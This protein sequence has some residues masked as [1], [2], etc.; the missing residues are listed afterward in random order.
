MKRTSNNL[1]ERPYPNFH[2]CRLEDPNKYPEKTY[3]K[4]DQKHNG[5]CIDVVYGIRKDGKSE[6]QALRFD[7][8][9]WTE[10]DART[11]CKDRGGT[12]EASKKEE[13]KQQSSEKT[14]YQC[15]CIECGYK[16]TSTTH[17]N[18]L[19]CPKCGGRMRRVE[20]PGPGQKAAPVSSGSAPVE[21][22]IQRS[23]LT[24]RTYQVRFDTL[25]EKTRSIEAVIATENPVLVIDWNRWEIIEEVL[26]MS[27]FRAPANGQVPLL[28]THDRSTIQKQLGSTR[29]LHTEGDKLIGRN[30]FSS[31]PEAEH[32]WTLTKEGHLTDNSAGYRVINSVIIP[33]G[34]QATVEGRPFK[35]SATRDLRISTEWMHGETSVCPIGADEDAKN[36]NKQNVSTERN[37]IMDPKFKEWL[38]ARGENPET[39][40]EK[41]RAE[42]EAE[43]KAEQQR[44]ENE[45]SAKPDKKDG[46]RTDPIIND[47]PTDTRAIAE[48]AVRAERDRV[49]TIRTLGGE[50]VP[51][52]V[53]ET[54]IREGKTIEQTKSDVLDAV[55]KNRPKVSPN[56][57]V[58]SEIN[59]EVLEDAMLLRAGSNDVILEDKKK[60]EQRAEAAKRFRDMS[61]LDVCR[62][63]LVFAGQAIPMGREEVIRAAFSTME[64]PIILGNIAKKSLLKGYNSVPATWRKWCS[65][66]SVS[67]FKEVTGARLTDT[68]ELEQVGNSGEVKYGAAT[69]EYEK[70]SVAT[71][72]KNFGVTRQN[73][74][75][76]DLRVLTKVPQAMGARAS[77]KAGDLVYAHLMLNGAMT[78][79]VALFHATH[80]NLNT[81][82]TLAK[83]K[84]AAAIVAFMKQV[85]KDDQPINV[86]P[87]ILLVP[88]ELRFT[89]SELVKSATIVI[90]GTSDVVRP[91]YNA[92]SDMNI[93]VVTEARL[94]N[95]TYTGYSAT[96]WYMTGDPNI[97]DTIVVAFLNGRQEPTLEQ[98]NAGP[99]VMG[100]IYRIFTDVGCKSL[101]FRGMQ[102]NTT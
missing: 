37:N 27:G 7:K 84:L 28:D 9:I 45:P 40:D 11:V 56:I 14:V 22:L 100:I 67:D 91:T 75:N 24:T 99:N 65:V 62:Q 74:I 77:R 80:L 30:F 12:F 72:A 13:Q 102:K 2:S 95:A 17:C 33:R 93:E 19:K 43:Y 96:S 16:E 6:I 49:E 10:S 46:Q 51:A 63:A 31:S 59:R 61:L 83:D 71:Y 50:D 4:C 97:V 52:E 8:K 21:G 60:G 18:D 25:D 58:T 64:L 53:I 76:D 41:K 39:L 66:D 5:K 15:E 73:I 23:E 48:E 3:G 44:S 42:L 88:P 78:D 26:L 29:Q 20:R 86:E 54:C 81:T 98:F 90:T 1:T 47:P 94:S 101:D 85:D 92:I 89:A 57:E 34:E 69:E 82:A 79:T 36:R 87:R 55:R 32:A 70:Y 38:I 68:G 35:A